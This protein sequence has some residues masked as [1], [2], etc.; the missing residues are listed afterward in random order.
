M[1]RRKGFTLVE[2]IIASLILGLMMAIGIPNFMTYRAKQACSR[3]ADI[4]M[5]DLKLCKERAVALDASKSAGVA[6]GIM[7]ASVTE[8]DVYEVLLDTDLAAA[9]TKP[10]RR[11]KLTGLGPSVQYL[12]AP[13]GSNSP[14]YIDFYRRPE[15]DWSGMIMVFSG[16]HACYIFIGMTS[17]GSPLPGNIEISKNF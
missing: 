17:E 7:P 3:A 5:S 16:R 14:S 13:S 15:D 8:Y 1:S 9:G 12:L 6:T 2:I 4:I 10:V 11:V